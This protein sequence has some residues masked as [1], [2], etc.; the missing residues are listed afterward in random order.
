MK[1]GSPQRNHKPARGGLFV[2]LLLVFTFPHPVSAQSQLT[3]HATASSRFLA[4]HGRRAWAAGYSNL[5]LEI[6]TGALQIASEVRP[7]FR[8]AGD[9]SLIPGTQL[10]S[11]V[12]AQPSHFSRTYTGP[13]F[14]VEEEIWAPLDEK[15]VLLLYRV[16]S[17]RPLQVIVRFRPSLNLMWPAAIGGQE[18]RWDAKQSGYFLSDPAHQF[19][20]VVLAPGAPAHDEPLNSARSLPQSDE[21]SVALNPQMPRLLFAEVKNGDPAEADGLRKLLESSQWRENSVK[22]YTDLLASELKIETPDLELNRALAWAEIALDQNWFCN[23]SL[24]CGYVAGWGPSRRNRRPQYAW[25][26]ANDGLIALHAALAADD[27]GHAREE[28][29]FIAKYQDQQNGMIWHE[30]SQSAPYIDWRGKY[31]YMFVHADVTYPYISAIADYLRISND[32]AFLREIWPSVQKAYVYGRALAGADGLPRIPEGKEGADEQDS[33][34]EE[35]A[36]SAIWIA[37]AQD[38][39]HLADRVGDAQSALEAR[40][41]AQKG[42]LAFLQRYWDAKHEFPIQGY[43]RTG[44]PMQDRG[45]GAVDAIQQHLFTQAQTTRILDEIA[46]WRF[47]SDWGTRSVAMGEPGFDP[48]GYAHGSVW[49]L[50]TAE[51]AQAYWAAHRPQTAWQ[52]W[53]TLVPWWS[54]D[55]PGHMHEVLAGDT[56][57][58]QLE[59]VPEQSWSSAAFLSSA[60]HGLFGLDIDAE[61]NTLLLAPHLP[62]EWD[63]VTLTNVVIRDSKLDLAFEQNVDSLTVRLNNHGGPVQVNF[64]PEIPLGV[65]SVSATINGRQAPVHLQTN[66]ED[67]HASLELSVPQGNAEVIVRY[68]DGVQVLTRQHTPILGQQSSG[69]KLTS[70][71]F[72]NGTLKID[73]DMIPAEDNKIIVRTQRAMRN[74]ERCTVQKL[75]NDQYEL[76][77]TFAS[78]KDRNSYD[79]EQLTIVFA[80]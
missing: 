71:S 64:Q 27:L 76:T 43:R 34:R 58:P 3:T 74:A 39:A 23:D 35:L 59:S 41:L 25:F 15:S 66:A 70:I 62:P 19:T 17:R 26:F 28:I 38:Y 67:E 57:H 18:I 36:L 44:E 22:H 24:G 60:V 49:G 63:R 37:A 32:G 68:R 12:E 2:A 48:T 50:G 20:A 33:L 46:S 77:P 69:M 1:S 30:L 8:R 72:E 75:G 11:M 9:V 7:E 79:H 78:E 55:S 31:P 73:V 40:A 29:R 52:I 80:N 16:H 56:F 51:V 45:L 5:G 42:R 4:A 47:Q 21:L 13:D 54:L 14:S 65:R 10:V 6:W 61:N 53:R